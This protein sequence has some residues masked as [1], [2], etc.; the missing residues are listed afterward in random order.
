MRPRPSSAGLISIILRRTS[1]MLVI[2]SVGGF[3]NGCCAG[4][5]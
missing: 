1:A 5:R 3:G 4:V 2:V